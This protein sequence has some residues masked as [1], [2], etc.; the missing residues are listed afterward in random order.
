VTRCLNAPL[1]IPDE[2]YLL[3][4]NWWEDLLSSIPPEKRDRGIREVLLSGDVGNVEVSIV[5][6]IY[7]GLRLDTK[8]VSDVVKTSGGKTFH[9]GLSTPRRKT[10]ISCLQL[11]SGEVVGELIVLFRP[12]SDS[13]EVKLAKGKFHP[14][15]QAFL[16]AGG[17]GDEASSSGFTQ[18]N[19]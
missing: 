1:E 19:F 3:S 17:D 16:P 10:I 14:W 11:S 5:I 18:D 15:N 7:E 2:E 8:E 6:T 4:G 13:L 9:Y 12:R